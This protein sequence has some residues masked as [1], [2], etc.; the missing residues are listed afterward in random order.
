MP[1]IG[2]R[3]RDDGERAQTGAAGG[4]RGGRAGGVECVPVQAPAGVLRRLERDAVGRARSER[5]FHALGYPRGRGA[6]AGEDERVRPRHPGLR[7]GQDGGGVGRGDHRCGGQR[8]R[9]R[10]QR[11][12][13][14]AVELLAVDRAPRDHGEEAPAAVVA[15]VRRGRDRVGGAVGA[16]VLTEAAGGEQPLEVLA[17]ADA[18]AGGRRSVDVVGLDERLERQRGRVVVADARRGSELAGPQLRER[19]DRGR[20]LRDDRAAAVAGRELAELPLAPEQPQGVVDARLEPRPELG[21]A[22]VGLQPR[23]GRR[24]GG[25]QLADTRPRSVV[26]VSEA[27]AEAR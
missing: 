19:R 23:P 5:G 14:I 11:D 20:D 15:R 10:A 12:L 7:D 16:H 27:G 21:V 22:R 13:E 1:G 17:G 26:T 24:R 25:H 2:D 9:L 3:G 4:W 8:R 18:H 6:G